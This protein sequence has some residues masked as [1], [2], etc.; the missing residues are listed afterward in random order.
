[1][2]SM[3]VEG[4]SFHKEGFDLYSFNPN[5]TNYGDVKQNIQILQNESDEAKKKDQSINAKYQQINGDISKFIQSR[6]ELITD[7]KY[8]YSGNS[9][10]DL[11][12][13]TDPIRNTSDVRKDDIN[14]L[15]LQQ[16]YIYIVGTIT[17]AT[18]LIGA[19]VIGRN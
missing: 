15:L 4:F 6:G 5:P 8:D 13:K 9:M 18:L 3:N 12:D 1:M 2:Y 7:Q 10:M 19:I 16:N 14:T 11:P 17:C